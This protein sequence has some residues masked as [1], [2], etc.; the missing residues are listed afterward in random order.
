MNG[1]E[2]GLRGYLSFIRFAE[3]AAECRTGYPS[4]R[5]AAIR[6]LVRRLR[7]SARLR[8]AEIERA[9]WSAVVNGSDQ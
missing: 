5:R 6:Q 1:Y 7:P 8:Q 9:Y 4:D 3:L 2:P